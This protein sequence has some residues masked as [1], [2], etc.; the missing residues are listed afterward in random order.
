MTERYH[1]LCTGYLYSVWNGKLKEYKGNVLYSDKWTVNGYIPPELTM[2][3]VVDERGKKIKSLNCALKEGV[4]YNKVVWLV[5]SDRSKAAKILIDWE[6]R[7]ISALQMKINNHHGRIDT[8]R[9][10]GGL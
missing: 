1:L 6:M 2:F 3:D 9:E 7:Q 4:V 10:E 8:V 5:E